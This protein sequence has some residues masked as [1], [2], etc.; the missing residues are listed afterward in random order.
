MG[1]SQVFYVKLSPFSIFIYIIT[2]CMAD[3]RSE[4]FVF[5]DFGKRMGFPIKDILIY[6]NKLLFMTDPL[7]TVDVH[8]TDP[9]IGCIIA[10]IELVKATIA[11][12]CLV[13]YHFW[14]Q[15]LA[16]TFYT[17]TICHII[18]ASLWKINRWEK[19]I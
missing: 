10:A 1:L 7:Q 8:T 16:A 11:V 14:F 12:Y 6:I 2:Y 9:T 17:K 19:L 5:N 13:A 4:W 18:W 3:W 15:F